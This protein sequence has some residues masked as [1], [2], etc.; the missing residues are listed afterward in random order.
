LINQARVAAGKPILGQLNPRIYKIG[1]ANFHDDVGG[2]NGYNAVT[3]YDL[4]TGLGSPVINK[5]L[6]TLV[7]QP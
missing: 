5:L 6:P 1:A 4:V 2:S 7:A 3:G